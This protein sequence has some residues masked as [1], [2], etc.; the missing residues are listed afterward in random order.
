MSVIAELNMVASRL[1]LLA[2]RWVGGEM[3]ENRAIVGMC[4]HGISLPMNLH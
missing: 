2:A 3:T 1:L 4:A